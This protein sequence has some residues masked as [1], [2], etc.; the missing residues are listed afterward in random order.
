MNWRSTSSCLFSQQLSDSG[1]ATTLPAFGFPINFSSNLFWLWFAWGR[2]LGACFFFATLLY[3]AYL[4][5]GVPKSDIVLAYLS[6]FAC[7][8]LGG[9][10]AANLSDIGEDLVNYKHRQIGCIVNR[11]LLDIHQSFEFITKA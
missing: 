9:I 1:K 3:L 10:D 7:Q 6:S 8:H 11:Q 2:F 5:L 4:H